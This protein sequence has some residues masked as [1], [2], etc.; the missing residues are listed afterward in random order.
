MNMLLINVKK[1]IFLRKNDP[2]NEKNFIYFNLNKIDPMTVKKFFEKW[3]IL[4][5]HD[6]VIN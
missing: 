6:D 2:N 4:E 3:K 5:T 1:L